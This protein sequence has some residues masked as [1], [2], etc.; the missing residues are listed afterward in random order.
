M[1][2]LLGFL[3]AGQEERRDNLERQSSTRLSCGETAATDGDLIQERN[4]FQLKR[5][6]PV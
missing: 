1:L 6:G 4:V 5:A 2:G 3:L